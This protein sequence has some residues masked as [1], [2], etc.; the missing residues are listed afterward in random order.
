L[1]LQQPDLFCRY[2]IYKSFN[3]DSVLTTSM[4]A[5]FNVTGLF[6][7]M[8]ERRGGVIDH[9]GGEAL[10][11]VVPNLGSL[12]WEAV[13]EFRAHQGSP[14]AR[15]KLRQFD[16]LPADEEPQDVVRFQRRVS[17]EVNSAIFGAWNDLRPNLPEALGMEAAKTG[18]S[19]YPIVGPFI[20]SGL[21]V[22]EALARD[23]QDRRSWLAALWKLRDYP[24]Q[25]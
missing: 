12:P 7:P 21:S 1:K 13:I 15:A 19:L 11:V 9:P 3:R 20:A 17:Q 16:E 10:G 14:E 5:V 24:G 23:F 2:F 25:Y 18:V 6:A 8:I 22:S 4:G